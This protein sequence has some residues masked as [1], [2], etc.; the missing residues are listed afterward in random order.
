M[1]A[2]VGTIHAP[3]EH[4]P[5]AQAGSRKRWPELHAFLMP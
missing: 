3:V 1:A 5:S 2:D 4:V